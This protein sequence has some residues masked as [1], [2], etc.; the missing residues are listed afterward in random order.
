MNKSVASSKRKFMILLP[1]IK[2][3][4]KLNHLSQIEKRKKR[5]KERSKKETN[6]R[7]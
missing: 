6:K 5:A 7:R 1:I 2:R 3:V 4:Q